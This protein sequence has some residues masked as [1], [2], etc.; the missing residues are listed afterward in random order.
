MWR[1]AVCVSSHVVDLYP[2]HTVEIASYATVL[3]QSAWTD[4]ALNEEPV[5]M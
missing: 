2:S 4:L 3:T 5:H 1:M